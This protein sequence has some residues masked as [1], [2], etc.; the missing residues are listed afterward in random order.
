MTDQ[1]PPAV[2]LAQVEQRLA[3]LQFDRFDE[4][5]AW[6]VGA[7]LRQRAEAD[8]VAVTVE[9]RLLG[10]TVF[11]SAMPGTSPVNADWARRKRNVAE[12]LH[13]ASY[14]VGLE[15]RVGG[16]SVLD[17]MGLDR[18]DFADHGGAVPVV[19]RGVGA[20]GVVTVSGLPQRDDHELVMHVLELHR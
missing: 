6:T 19:V 5:D 20:V 18:R 3:S 16:R 13:R 7:A 1:L 14:A 11:L 2:E 4:V 10:A 8:G 12:L 15:A 17:E 9:V